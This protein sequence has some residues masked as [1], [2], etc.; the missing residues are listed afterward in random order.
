MSGQATGLK[1][2]ETD[3]SV[4]SVKVLHQPGHLSLRRLKCVAT[5]LSFSAASLFYSVQ[6]ILISKGPTDIIMFQYS[7]QSK[8]AHMGTYVIKI[9]ALDAF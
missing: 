5:G 2:Q 6:N 3:S 4:K 9:L 7:Y 1:I 8:I